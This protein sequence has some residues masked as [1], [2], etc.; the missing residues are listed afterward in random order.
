MCKWVH[1]AVFDL[2]LGLIMAVAFIFVSKVVLLI[3]LK[4]DPSAESGKPTSILSVS[5]VSVANSASTRYEI[6]K[7][8]IQGPLQPTTRAGGFLCA[9]DFQNYP[10]LT[11]RTFASPRATASPWIPCKTANRHSSFDALTSRCIIEGTEY[12]RRRFNIR[13]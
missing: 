11:C 10:L 7:K 8:C 3:P 9:I 12:R 13:T 6:T 5:Q 4:L 1:Y 2:C